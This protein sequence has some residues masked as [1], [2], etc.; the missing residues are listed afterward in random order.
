[1]IRVLRHSTAKGVAPK[2]VAAVF[3]CVKNAC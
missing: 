1:M 3:K 2:P